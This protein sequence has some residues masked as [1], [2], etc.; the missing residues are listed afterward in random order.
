MLA[1]LKTNGGP[2]RTMLPM[3]GSPAIGA[4]KS[5]PMTDQRGVTRKAD[6]CTVGAVEVP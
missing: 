3:M 6:G 2:T 5:C 1:P 4:G